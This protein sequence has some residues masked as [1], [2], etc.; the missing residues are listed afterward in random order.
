LG[1]R[2]H[3]VRASLHPV[4]AR[5]AVLLRLRRR[6]RAPC[7]PVADAVHA[8]LRVALLG[9]R[10]RAGAAVGRRQCDRVGAALRS[11]AAGL[12]GYRMRLTGPRF[13]MF[14]VQILIVRQSQL[15][16]H[17]SPNNIAWI[18]VLHISLL[19]LFAAVSCMHYA[20]PTESIWKVFGCG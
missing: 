1:L 7:A 14:I 20:G 5:R 13:S 19:S 16:M 10:R 17:L 3:R 11:G 4:A 2:H 9:L 12:A 18:T 8:R 6:A 15:L